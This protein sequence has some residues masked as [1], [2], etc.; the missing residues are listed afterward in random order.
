MAQDQSV[1]NLNAT[2]LVP[3]LNEIDGIKTIMPKIDRSLFSQILVV[4][5][6]STDG[7]AEAA[8]QLGFEVYVQKK[9]GIRHAYL[10]A[11]PLIRGD[12]V[13]TFSPDGNCLVEDLHNILQGLKE[14]ADMVIASRY[15]KWAKSEDDNFVTA[16]GNYM[17]TKLINLFHGGKFSDAMT[18]YRGYRTK[19][20]HELKLD[21]EDGY[22]PEKYFFTVIGIEP[23]LSIRFAK[24]KLLLLD[25]PSPEPKRITG[26]AKLQVVRWGASYL[27]QVFREI[28]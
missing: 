6:D 3:V 12:Y 19:I 20:F 25:I 21:Q 24:N 15:Y 22:L 28:F 7:T 9:K 26:K 10:E 14:G 18:I 17:F 11:W 16:F 8:R 4:D 5:G 27:V 2:L 23:L 1:K 13:I